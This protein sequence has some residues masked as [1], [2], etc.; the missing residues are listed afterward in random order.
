MESYVDGLLADIEAYAALGLLRRCRT[1]YIGG[2]TPSFLGPNLLGKLVASVR[3]A[4]PELMELSFEANPDSLT[5]EVLARAVDA[6]ATRVSIGVQSFEDEELAALGRL[7]SSAVAAER[8]TVARERGLDVSLDL[9]C[10]IPKQSRN[11]WAHTLATAIGLSP[12]HVSVYPLAIEE[13]TPFARAYDD[14][15]TPWN[16]EDVQAERM[17]QA[18]QALEEAGYARYEVASYARPGHACLHNQTY[19]TGVPYL[20]VGD[21]AASMI[22]VEQ[23]EALRGL[24]PTLPEPPHATARVRIATAGGWECE[25]MTERQAW[26]E[27]L[28]LG[29]RLVRGVDA[30]RVPE[31]VVDGL[32]SRKLVDVRDGRMVPTHDGWLLGNELYGALWDLAATDC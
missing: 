18:E 29:M 12:D 10:A 11:T 25:F 13:G 5:N 16:S 28:M 19:W 27:D 30:S 3:S 32:Q 4:C 23:Y 31:E 17:E 22:D 21:G 8:I 26:A 15:D 14:V 24:D 9:M 6:G 2:G 20:G 7:H 1:A